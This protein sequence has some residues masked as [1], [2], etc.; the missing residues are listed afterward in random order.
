MIDYKKAFED[1]VSE[2]VY[3]YGDNISV[4]D[5]ESVDLTD[6]LEPSTIKAI[7]EVYKE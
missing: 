5:I 4:F 1:L 2:V 3:I 7:Y 6:E